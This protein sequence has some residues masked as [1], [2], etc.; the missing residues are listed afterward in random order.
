MAKKYAQEN[1]EY[2]RLGMY[3]ALCKLKDRSMTELC[4]KM[5]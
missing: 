1:C 2:S 3:I 4:P 5:Y